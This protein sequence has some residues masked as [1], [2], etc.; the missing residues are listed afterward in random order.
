MDVDFITNAVVIDVIQAIP[1]AILPRVIREGTRQRRADAR[2]RII[3]ARAAVH[4]AGT[5]RKVAEVVA[6]AISGR[7]VIAGALQATR[8]S[9]CRCAIAAAVDRQARRRNWIRVIASRG[10]RAAVLCVAQ[11]ISVRVHIDVAAAT[12]ARAE[13]VRIAWTGITACGDVAGGLG[14]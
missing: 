9:R 3:I 10:V 2:R 14:A 13:F 1:V 6:E 12:G 4:A 8:H 11:T 7:V 5:A